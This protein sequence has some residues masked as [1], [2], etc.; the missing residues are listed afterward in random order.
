MSLIHLAFINQETNIHSFHGG[1]KILIGEWG[2]LS[3]P[4]AVLKPPLIKTHSDGGVGRIGRVTP[5]PLPPL[6]L[7]T[8]SQSIWESF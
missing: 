8:W 5:I 3:S 4:Y 2:G 7:Y 6:H 1:L